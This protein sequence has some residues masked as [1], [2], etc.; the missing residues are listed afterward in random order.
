MDY[1]NVTKW[2]KSKEILEN[3]IISDK[4]KWSNITDSAHG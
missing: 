1:Y 3:Q 4:C 2:E